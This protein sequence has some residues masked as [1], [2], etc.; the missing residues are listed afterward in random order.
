ML[1]CI[2]A[3]AALTF[4]LALSRKK[5][6]AAGTSLGPKNETKRDHDEPHWSG[7]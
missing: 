3:I 1:P 2:I 7:R 4:T 5:A 6:D